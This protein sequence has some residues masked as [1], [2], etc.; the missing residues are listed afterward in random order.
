M[1][2]I[3]TKYARRDCWIVRIYKHDSHERVSQHLPHSPEPVIGLGQQMRASHVQNHLQQALIIAENKEKGARS[4][5]R[6]SG[7]EKL[8]H[9]LVPQARVRGHEEGE[10]VIFWHKREQSE[11]CLLACAARDRRPA[12]KSI[13][14]SAQHGCA[15]WVR[16]MT[17]HKQHL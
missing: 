7:R 11:C 14:V 15:T 10:N 5:H 13:V 16:N 2:K 3:C 1:H 17:T 6:C 4:F 8:G 9:V 12:T